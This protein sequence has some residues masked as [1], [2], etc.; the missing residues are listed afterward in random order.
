MG[1]S[2]TT[3]SPSKAAP[4]GNVPAMQESGGRVSCL[5]LGLA[6]WGMGGALTSPRAS[7]ASLWSLNPSPCLVSAQPSTSSLARTGMQHTDL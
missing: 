1:L 6:V 7:G 2:C 4:S 3:S 5:S